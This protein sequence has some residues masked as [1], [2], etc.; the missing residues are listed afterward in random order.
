MP[1]A[2]GGTRR[3]RSGALPWRSGDVVTV[4]FRSIDGRFHAGRPVRVIEHTPAR[5]VTY[6]AEGT[7]VSA[8]TLTDGRGLREVP[9]DERWLHPR[10]SERR[11]WIG[12][13]L[14]QIFPA[15]RAHS[16]WV[17][18]RPDR[19]LVGWYVNLEDPHVLGK[20]TISTRDHVLD[21]WVPAE[22]GEPEWKDEDEL[23]A[24][25]V[26]GRVTAEQAAEIRAEGERVWRERPWPTGWE[27]WTPPADWVTPDLPE[28]WD[29]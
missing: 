15:G 25:I 19:S 7:V 9:L 6:M 4:R 20:R 21:V 3:G 1:A 18:R 2:A 13:E 8:P 10:A 17:V 14:I 11:P 16:L 23:E 29:G 26:Q 24:A 22:T 5:V 27:S 28:G 12:T